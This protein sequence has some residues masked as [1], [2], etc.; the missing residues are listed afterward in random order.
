[1]SKPLAEERRQLA[2]RAAACQAAPRDSDHYNDGM[3]RLA[4]ALLLLAAACS[5][6]S[7]NQKAQIAQPEIDVEQLVGPQDLGYV[8][9][10]VDLQFELRVANP[11]AEPLTLKR[12]EV[13][14]VN[15][16]AYQLRRESYLF[17]ETIQPNQY[18][19]V[20]FWAHAYAYP[21]RTRQDEPVTFRGVA[22][23]STPVG[24]LQ[25]VFIKNLSQFGGGR[26]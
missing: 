4:V 10:Q 9:G 17:N 1:M 15:G 22:Y 11:A 12:V 13:A 19:S 5:S 20:K 23:F 21:G 24:P 25:K 14:S 26:Q 3:K 8:T 6:G 16:G 18:T 7:K 2:G